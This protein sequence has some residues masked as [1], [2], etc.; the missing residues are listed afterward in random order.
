MYFWLWTQNSTPFYI[1]T[2]SKLF[3]NAQW[4]VLS[5]SREGWILF[6]LEIML[7]VHH[8]KKSCHP[9]SCS[10]RIWITNLTSVSI[11]FCGSHIVS[12][13]HIYVS[14]L[15]F[16]SFSVDVIIQLHDEICIILNKLFSFKVFLIL[17]VGHYIDN[18]KWQFYII[19][20]FH[21]RISYKTWP[22]ILYKR[23]LQVQ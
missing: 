15:I 19:C 12:E 4:K 3:F 17:Q 5:N 6:C 1:Y 11:C 9:C 2:Q 13:S 23:R 14:I 22:K 10:H 18:F 8:L 16:I 20:D 7:R 21:F